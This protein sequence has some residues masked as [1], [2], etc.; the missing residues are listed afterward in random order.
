MT[1][2]T[3]IIEETQASNTQVKIQV[4]PFNF[5]GNEIRMEIINNE[6]W[7]LA[8]D[9]C[10]IL[11]LDNVSKALDGLDENETTLLKV[12][13]GGQ[14]R[15]MYAVNESGMYSL[16]FKSRKPEAKEFKRWVT[17]EV[18]PAIRK[19]GYYEAKPQPIIPTASD[20]LAYNLDR[21]LH[22]LDHAIKLLEFL[23]AVAFPANQKD[24]LE[25]RGVVDGL[26]K[27]VERAQTL[28]KM[29]TP[30]IGFADNPHR[31]HLPKTTK[32]LSSWER[33]Y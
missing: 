27:N 23:N 13:W 30:P 29:V 24:M 22:D 15:E 26:I 20:E 3:Q 32:R 1:Q 6:P 31:V 10:N 16:I 9:I 33:G 18:L 12:M 17:S 4:A 14:N 25:K 7:F 5:N 11:S 2:D 21:S 28:I 19:Y 8:K